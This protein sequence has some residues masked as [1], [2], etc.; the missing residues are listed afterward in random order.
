MIFLLILILDSF[1]QKAFLHI[2]SNADL[3]SMKLRRTSTLHTLAFSTIGCTMNI[4]LIVPLLERKPCWF[5]SINSSL[6]CFI[7]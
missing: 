4:V 6:C 2:V 3:K 1:F 5:S 7:L